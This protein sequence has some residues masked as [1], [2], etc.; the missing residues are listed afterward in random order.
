M[1]PRVCLVCGRGEPCTESPEACTFDPTPREL[2]D[3][4]KRLRDELAKA[5]AA[6]KALGYD[7]I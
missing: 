2:Y 7:Q 5:R 1:P 4:N 3:E 6:L